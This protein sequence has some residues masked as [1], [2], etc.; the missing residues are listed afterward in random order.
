MYTV[1]SI[2]GRVFRL[3]F[4]N[5]KRTVTIRTD[6]GFKYR[7]YPLSKEE[8]QSVGFW[9]GNDVQNFLKTDEYYKV[10]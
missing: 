2:A 8:F 7:S 6:S 3:S 1:K 10:K 4:N 9:T 5:S